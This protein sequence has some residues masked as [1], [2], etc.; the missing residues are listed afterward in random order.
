MTL[1][2]C[3]SLMAV[4]TTI[5]TYKLYKEYK[6]ANNL[7]V[8]VTPEFCR[9]YNKID[10]ERLLKMDFGLL[11]ANIVTKIIEK[12]PDCDLTLFYNNLETLTISLCD[13]KL[14][15]LILGTGHQAAYCNQSNVIK[16][17][18]SNGRQC[19]AHELFHVAS[20][21]VYK[22]ADISFSGFKQSFGNKRLAAGINEGYTQLLKE[23]YFGQNKFDKD[24]Y[25]YEKVIASMLEQII[26]KEKMQSLYLNANLYGLIKELMTYTD[27]TDIVS[28]VVD[29]D[30]IYKHLHTRGLLP[31]EESI[32]IQKEK[33][34][35]NFLFNCY[36]KKLKVEFDI[37]GFNKGILQEKVTTFSNMMNQ[38]YDIAVETSSYE[39]INSILCN[40][41]D[42]EYSMEHQPKKYIKNKY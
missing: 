15:N 11:T 30:F 32:I 39:T 25:K 3:T 37:N 4:S 40:Y 6:E 36:I 20:T 5:K 24:L 21:I 9:T 14:K 27:E 2:G 18:K 28:F 42:T 34:I 1:I 29:T 22:G 10:W 38:V 31:F 12:I 41:L 23:R 33:N 13:Y 26:G 16:L 19:I 17:Q 8:F 35:N 7:K